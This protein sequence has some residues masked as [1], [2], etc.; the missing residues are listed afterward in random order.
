MAT[1]KTPEDVV[2][3]L[4]EFSLTINRERQGDF[5][6]KHKAYDCVLSYGDKHISLTYQSNPE[7]D[8]EPTVTDIVQSMVSDAQSFDDNRNIDDFAAAFGYVGSDMPISKVLSVY[9]GCKENYEWLCD[10]YGKPL[11]VNDLP[12]LSDVLNEHEAEIREA[13]E[14]IHQE[15]AELDAYNNPVVPEGFVSIQEVM[16]QFDLGD[17]GDQITDHAE[18]EDIDSAFAEIADDN[19]NIYYN[20]LLSWLPENYEWIEEAENQGLLEGCKGD[21]IKMTQIAQYVCFESD[22]YDHQDDIVSYVAA[23]H[24]HD[25]GVYM[26]SDD[27]SDSLAICGENASRLDEGIDTIKDEIRN[28]LIGHFEDLYGDSDL[29]E[30]MADD[31]IDSDFTK[32]NPCIMNTVAVRAVAELG[33]DQ[34]FQNDWKDTLRSHHIEK[35]EQIIEERDSDA[36]A[37]IATINFSVWEN[38]PT[39]EVFEEWY[40]N[41]YGNLQF[42]EPPED[43]FDHNEDILNDSFERLDAMMEKPE[44]RWS[45]FPNMVE[46][47]STSLKES[48]AQKRSY[49]LSDAEKEARKSSACLAT[50]NGGKDEPSI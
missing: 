23:H 32:V 4:S 50:D 1:V 12:I 30:E 13:V 29:S 16:Q 39:E 14:R 47:D 37:M 46:P 40:A 41:D 22:L 10:N 31:I 28:Q 11:Y 6:S 18:S 48:G 20:Q 36:Y 38:L 9:N 33:Y 43:M 24:L 34:A 26:I 25:L 2:N 15:K 27:L 7:F 44:N 17:Y 21:L 49:S 8:G 35:L 42:E 3:W 5:S 19:V 45:L